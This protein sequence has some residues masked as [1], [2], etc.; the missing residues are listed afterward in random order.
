MQAAILALVRA[1]GGCMDPRSIVR[2]FASTSVE[3]TA[4]EHAARKALSLLID[5]GELILTLDRKVRIPA[6]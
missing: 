1:N 2:T 3:R 6:S 4:G 5:H